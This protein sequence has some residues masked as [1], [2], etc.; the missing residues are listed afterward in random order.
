[1]KKVS[2]AVTKRRK[3]RLQAILESVTI[4]L[5]TL[6]AQRAEISPDHS[7]YL[8]LI[9]LRISTAKMHREQLEMN[10]RRVS[11]REL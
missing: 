8:Q 6:N 4:K 10:L 5:S 7:K 11:G 2:T 3:A 1:M 9:D